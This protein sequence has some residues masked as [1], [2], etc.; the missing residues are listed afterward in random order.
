VKV[1]GSRLISK[2]GT[3]F[4]IGLSNVNSRI[5]LLF[6]NEFG[7]VIYSSEGYG[8]TVQMNLPVNET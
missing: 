5:K 1:T 2:S 4:S 3:R 6:G 8:T 7:L